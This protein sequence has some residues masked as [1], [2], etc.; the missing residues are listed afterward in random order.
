ML[1]LAILPQTSPRYA[2]FVAGPGAIC[3]GR[4]LP[5]VSGCVR[6]SVPLELL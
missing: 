3:S 2:V 6:Q 4:S 5:S 1:F